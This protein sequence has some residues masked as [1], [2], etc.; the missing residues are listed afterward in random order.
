VF[1]DQTFWELVPASDGWNIYHGDEG[2][3]NGKKERKKERK[4]EIIQITQKPIIRQLEAIQFWE[5]L[6]CPNFCR[7]VFQKLKTN[8]MR[9]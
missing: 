8:L 5:T 2:N 4:K 7:F 1:A 6:I 9:G 3:V